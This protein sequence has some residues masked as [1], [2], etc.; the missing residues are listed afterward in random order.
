VGEREFDAE[1]EHLEVVKTG[2]TAKQAVDCFCK[3]SE[4]PSRA[5]I[6]HSETTSPSLLLM[7]RMYKI[8][9]QPHTLYLTLDLDSGALDRQ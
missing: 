5:E 6:S 7:F 3:P 1:D 9:A 8:C 2:Y 4:C